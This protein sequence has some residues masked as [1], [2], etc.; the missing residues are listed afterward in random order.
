MLI[1]R[2]NEEGKLKVDLG[3]DKRWMAVKEIMKPILLL[4]I[5]D[6]QQQPVNS[7]GKE[8]SLFGRWLG[9]V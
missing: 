3:R 5:I 2:L 8:R 4:S 9:Q 7:L 6:V 1:R